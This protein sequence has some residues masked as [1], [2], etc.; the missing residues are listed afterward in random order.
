MNEPQTD[1]QLEEAILGIISGMDKPGSPAGEAIKACFANLHHRGA[2]WQRKIRFGVLSSVPILFALDTARGH[3][4][5]IA[6]KL[7]AFRAKRQD[8]M[9]WWLKK[10]D[11]YYK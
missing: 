3:N 10:N 4:K 11:D 8:N 9:N 1:E 7:E 2:D 5:N 6:D